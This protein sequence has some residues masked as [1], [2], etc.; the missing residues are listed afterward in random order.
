VP[1]SPGTRNQADFLTAVSPAAS[2]PR[3]RGPLGEHLTDAELKPIRVQKRRGTWQ[4]DYGSY[5][6]GYHASREEA[7]SA[8][9]THALYENRELTIERPRKISETAQLAVEPTVS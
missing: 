1:C 4:V 7:I 8:A 6:Q 9:M 2:E 3:Q 5:A